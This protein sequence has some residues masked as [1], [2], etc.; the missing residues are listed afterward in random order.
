MNHKAPHR[1][2]LWGK[3]WPTMK[4]VR[5]VEAAAVVVGA[6]AMA[7]EVGQVTAAVGQAAT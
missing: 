3:Q 5:A 7:S 1:P 4:A 6:V 2:G